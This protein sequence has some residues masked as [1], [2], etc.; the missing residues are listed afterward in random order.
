MF[1]GDTDV[2]DV[3][4]STDASSFL[5][6]ERALLGEDADQFATPHDSRLATTVEDAD[7]DLL[8]GSD[9]YQG[10]DSGDLQ[11]FESSFPDMD[12][13]NEV[14]MLSFRACSPKTLTLSCRTLDLA[15]PLLAQP[16]SLLLHTPHPPKNPKSLSNGA[17]NAT[18]K[19]PAVT[20]F[21]KTAKQ[22][23]STKPDRQLTTSTNHITTRKI[24]TLHRLVVKLRNF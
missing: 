20:A 6:R 19:L 24:R 16:P 22:P 2:R 21:P 23:Q 4:A 8:G 7:D 1:L 15:D 10:G 17:R 14:T 13:A 18:K 9:N 5:D 11:D 12:P 3:P